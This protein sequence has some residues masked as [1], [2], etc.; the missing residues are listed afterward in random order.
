MQ[1]QENDRSALIRRL[2]PTHRRASHSG[3]P[4]G[5]PAYAMTFAMYGSELVNT[6]LGR[7]ELTSLDAA[8]AFCKYGPH[9]PF[10]H[11]PS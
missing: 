4:A 7:E 1:S 8:L 6:R 10:Y 3:G 11:L 5:R 9:E 2:V